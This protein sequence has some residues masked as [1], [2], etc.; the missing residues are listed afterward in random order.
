MLCRAMSSRPAG[1]SWAVSVWLNFFLQVM[2]FTLLLVAALVST[3][4][5][6]FKILFMT[7]STMSSLKTNQ[8]KWEC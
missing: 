7:S 4:G 1:I 8:R 3:V 6:T 2:D 5:V